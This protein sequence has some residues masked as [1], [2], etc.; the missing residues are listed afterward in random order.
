MIEC[1]QKKLI[2]TSMSHVVLSKCARLYGE[3]G[4]NWIYRLIKKPT[5]FPRCVPLSKIRQINIIFHSAYQGHCIEKCWFALSIVGY[6]WVAIFHSAMNDYSAFQNWLLYGV[7]ASLCHMS[8]N[9][10][11]GSLF[12][13]LQLK[14]KKR[15]FLICGFL[16]L[17]FG[18]SKDSCN[19]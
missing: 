1:V 5:F 15:R 19:W 2:Y 7:K 16:L 14:G 6:Y 11:S 8:T 4:F 10:I 17:L 9:I 12:N 18:T 3:T 13:L